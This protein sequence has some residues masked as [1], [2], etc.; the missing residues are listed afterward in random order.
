ME[1]TKK[2]I[3]SLFSGI[4]DPRV[5]NRCLHKLS[6]ILFI[7]FCTLLA[8]GEDF[9]DMEE[10]G[11]QREAWFKTVLELPNGIP[12]HDT[13]NRVLQQL[14]P[15]KLQDLLTKDGQALLDCLSGQQVALDGKKLRGSSPKSRG[16]KGLWVLNAWVCEHRLCIGQKKVGSKTNEIKAIPALLNTLDLRGAVVSI[17]AIGCQKP[18]AQQIRSKGAD[19]LLAV[20]KNQGFLLEMVSEAFVDN[21]VDKTDETWDYGH[22]RYE[23]RSCH[24][25]DATTLFI[26]DFREEWSGIGSLIKVHAK[27]IEKEKVREETRYYISS[28]RWKSAAYYNQLVRSH[29]GIENQLHWHL[30]VTFREDNCRA[31]T[32]NAAENLAIM[33]KMV[34]HR[35]AQAKDKLSLKKRRFRAALNMDYFLEL[36]LL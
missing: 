24:V 22:G 28:E 5:K 36:L 29:W 17:D 20:K 13:F 8:G 3:E 11:N 9:M 32:G 14:A 26:K 23:E 6:D 25:L 7:S 18:I 2:Q 12:T 35:I 33:R 30:D 21:R 4:E 19:Y 15:D 16:N 34:L 1:D 27:R 10:F 31:R